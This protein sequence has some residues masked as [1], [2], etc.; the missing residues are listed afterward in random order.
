MRRITCGA[1]LIITITPPGRNFYCKKGTDS[2][3]CMTSKICE[4]RVTFSLLK[5]FKLHSTFP[6]HLVGEI[7]SFLF[8][9]FST[10]PTAYPPPALEND[11]Y[12]KGPLKM[13]IES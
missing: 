2:L 10:L 3:I 1:E 4:L 6:H 9:F 8:F 12:R 7:D 13:A 11:E 5:L